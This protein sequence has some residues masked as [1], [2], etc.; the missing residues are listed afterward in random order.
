M[1]LLQVNGIC[2]FWHERTHVEK[3]SEK[4]NCAIGN[5]LQ[6]KTKAFH[7]KTGVASQQKQTC[8]IMSIKINSALHEVAITGRL[9]C[10]SYANYNTLEEETTSQTTMWEEFK[11]AA[12]GVNYGSLPS[13][14]NQDKIY[15]YINT[16]VFVTCR[17][18]QDLIHSDWAPRGP[19]FVDDLC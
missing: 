15:I 18:P 9:V 6:I 11:C 7:G 12:I 19:L 14:T 2:L 1:S 17:L 16:C 13:K 10:T 3:Q 8:L 4:P 5:S